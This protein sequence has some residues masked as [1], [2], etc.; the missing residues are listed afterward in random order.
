MLMGGEGVVAG[1]EGD[2]PWGTA[3]YLSIDNARVEVSSA[4]SIS[5]MRMVQRQSKQQG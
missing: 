3:A 5:G 2:D 1:M 4:R